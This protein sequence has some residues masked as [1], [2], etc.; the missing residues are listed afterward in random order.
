MDRSPL[1]A[2]RRIVVKV[3]TAVVTRP[4]GGLALGRL[5]RLAE[6]LHALRARGA[7][8]ILVTSGAIGLGAGRLR[9]EGPPTAVVDRQAC[10]AAGQGAL[11]AIYD[12]LLR[13]LG[14]VAAQVLLTEAD[15]LHRER[16]LHLHATLE[17]LLERGAVPIVNE[18]DTVSIAE[19][20]VG[21]DRVFGD[22]DRLSA[23]VAAGVD[24]ELLI[25]LTDVDGVYT[26]PPGSPGARRV[27]VWTGEHVAIGAGNAVGRGG[28]GA[29]I[30]A[31]EIA[32]HGG[33]QVVIAG[34][35]D[36]GVIGQI[37]AGED[38]GTWFPA[39]TGLSARRRWLAYATA[40][41]GAVR[42][43]DGARE[44]MVTRRAS[45][46]PAGVVGVSGEFIAG[47]VVSLRTEAGR[48]FARGIAG[49]SAGELR[50]LAGRGGRHKAVVHADNVVILHGEEE[51]A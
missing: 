17:R 14:H 8:V 19:L 40:P 41:A 29:K 30:R 1:T 3:G 51:G 50:E 25:L 21:R 4:D 7:E 38:V 46:L 13:Q 31:A 26:A 37:V 23:L 10:A 18:N 24:A 48:E 12:T 39:V 42:V 33:A 44:A 35:A 28:M 22:N 36:L 11:M 6:E 16:Y 27:P 2:A 5:G 32:V 49:R 9:Y 47:A 20:A 34:G 43:N 45:L 15:F